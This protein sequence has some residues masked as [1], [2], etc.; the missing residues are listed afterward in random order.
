V[1]GI[2]RRR[3]R[4]R[5]AEY[6]AERKNARSTGNQWLIFSE[7]RTLW[8]RRG[9]GTRPGCQ[10][11]PGRRTLSRCPENRA[12][13]NAVCP[14]ET[15]C[16]VKTVTTLGATFSTMGAKVVI[17]PSRVCCGCCAMTRDRL[18]F[19]HKAVSTNRPHDLRI[20]FSI[21]SSLAEKDRTHSRSWLFFDLAS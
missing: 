15:V 3:L 5:Q 21:N 16:V 18:A 10:R 6:L 20:P 13:E 8:S 17:M 14:R 2:L 1:P 12:N 11:W 7:R 4:R 9:C 19:T